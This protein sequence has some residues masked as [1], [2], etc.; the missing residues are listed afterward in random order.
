MS[1]SQ[2]TQ[3][4]LIVEDES[5]IVTYLEMLLHDAGFETAT[6]SNGKKGLEA[7]KQERPDL[8]TLDIS[9][10]ETSGT[11]FYKE[12]KT[13]PELASIP[14]VIVTGITGYGGDPYGY[15]KFVSN[16]RIVPPPEGFFPK[17]INKE[18]FLATVLKLLA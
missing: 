14:V 15:E 16:S 1:T 2:E 17:P 3:K 11:R 5:N 10:P 4:V 9:M 18:K 6:A 13:D 12:I 7:V 8:I